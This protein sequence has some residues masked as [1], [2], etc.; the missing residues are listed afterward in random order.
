MPSMCILNVINCSNM[1]NSLFCYL[2]AA[3]ML[4]YLKVVCYLV[5]HKWCSI[6]NRQQNA[7]EIYIASPRRCLLVF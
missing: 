4:T 1:L 6:M 3:Y 7:Q 2:R 5:Y